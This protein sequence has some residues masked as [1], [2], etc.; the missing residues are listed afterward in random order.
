MAFGNGPHHQEIMRKPLHSE[1]G[2]YEPDQPPDMR[3]NMVILSPSLTFLFN[4]SG[5]VLVSLMKI[6]MC[7]K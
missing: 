2:A 1:F 3:Y 6:S 7:P 4:S 5:N